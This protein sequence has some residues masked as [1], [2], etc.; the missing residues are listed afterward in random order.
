M[1]DKLERRGLGGGAASIIATCATSTHTPSHSGHSFIDDMN[2]RGSYNAKKS[3]QILAKDF[4]KG[5]ITAEQVY[6]ILEISDPEQAIVSASQQVLD[7]GKRRG[8]HRSPR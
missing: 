1:R 4:L 5:R 8:V 3:G 6:D 2:K 7:Y